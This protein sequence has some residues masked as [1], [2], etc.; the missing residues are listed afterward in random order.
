VDDRQLF[1]AARDGHVDALRAALDA[2]PAKLT[3]RD[4]PYE[5]T[6]LH[7]AAQH[8][9]LAI[10]NLLLDRGFDVNTLEKG[11]HTTA[12]HWAAA[13]GHVEVVHRLLDAGVDPLGHGDDHELEAIGWASCWQGTDPDAQR[14]IVKLLLDRGARHHIF[15]AIAMNLADEVRRIGRADRSALARP[16]SKFED[17]RLPLH[18]AVQMNRP[19][20]IEL[21]IRL[22]AN[23][24]G[25]DDAGFPP[26]AYAMEV[27]ADRRLHEVLRNA[28]HLDLFT[29]LAVD[30]FLVAAEILRREPDTVSRG[31][32]LHLMAKRGHVVAV[33]WL[34]ANGADADALWAHFDA[35]VTPLHMAVL[36]NHRDSV[37]ALLDAGANPGIRD[38]K[39]DSD[40]IGWAEFF[41]RPAL[42]AI[43]RSS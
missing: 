22:G 36:G 42:V 18:F 41:E 11:D 15:S 37:R 35:D 23:P 14:A 32:I 19:A 29:A 33:K 20:M 13:A 1:D 16:M 2:D 7:H 31:G 40:A 21:L 10:V 17:Y 12:L 6:L 8:G 25:T 26:A 38:S 9:H 34:L 28:G 27:D 24:F 5:W 4:Q 3:V 30:D 39:H 43:L